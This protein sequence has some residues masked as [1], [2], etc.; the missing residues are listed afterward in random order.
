MVT[1]KLIL[2]SYQMFCKV[3]FPIAAPGVYT[4][5][6][7]ER[8]VQQIA[9]G[10]R[11]LAEFGKKAKWGIVTSVHPDSGY[12]GHIKP[13][14]ALNPEQPLFSTEFMKFIEWL[15]EYYVAKQGEILRHMLPKILLRKLE[16]MEWEPETEEAPPTLEVCT[17]PLSDEQQTAANAINEFI[18]KSEHKTFLLQGVTGSG[19]SHVYYEL[20][21]KTLS[22]G[23]TAL[24]LVPEI[25]LTPQTVRNFTAA[26]GDEVAVLHSALTGKERA[27]NWT[28]LLTGKKRIAVGVRSAVF[29]PIKN[30]GLIVIDEE[31]DGS[32]SQ[33]ERQFSYSARDAAVMRA[34]LENAVIV[35]GSA[36]PSLESRRNAETGKY[37]L[38]RLTK[39]YSDRPL[40]KVHLVD[41][42]KEREVTGQ[43][44]FSRLLIEKMEERFARNE[45]II[46]LKNRRGYSPFVQC[47]KCGDVVMCPSCS[48]SLTYH[49]HIERLV[50]HYCDK[51]IKFVRPCTKCDGGTLY[52]SGAGV[53]RI[54]SELEK[55]FPGIRLLR[56]DLDT[57]SKR[58]ETA[59]IL[60]DF[61]KGNA[62]VLIGTQMVSKG[63]DFHRV[64]LVGVLL[65]ETGLYLPDFRAQEKAFQLLTQVS[66]RS[67]RGEQK[68]EVVIQTNLPNEF[69]IRAAVTQDFDRFYKEE[70]NIRKRLNYPP[71]TR[72]ALVRFISKTS[73][74]A[75]EVANLFAAAIP[76]TIIRLGPAPAPI[77]KVRNQYRHFV[78]LRGASSAALHTAVNAAVEAVKDAAKTSVKIQT[79]FDPDSLM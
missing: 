77:E 70:I 68:G 33:N 6:I 16:K 63:L 52:P 12:A 62:E 75:A 15:A 60:E 3:I 41:L 48:V 51:R 4:Y 37:S 1:I 61:R 40:P 9:T 53:E 29:A 30:I 28:K 42:K 64:T 74:K 78:I 43:T 65:A 7:P 72:M 13:I 5:E 39:R 23:R 69:V 25:S 73:A 59:R 21:N 54:Q 50:C 24:I 49:K 71:F 57:G 17:P 10:S 34:K 44:L 76:P 36:T 19:K 46:L 66:G 8:F 38:I 27:E 11:V 45:Q 55:K 47:D 26:F 2:F 14:T 58:G 31:H 20:V 79:I 18:S 32:Y 35:L 22:L 56:L 67:G